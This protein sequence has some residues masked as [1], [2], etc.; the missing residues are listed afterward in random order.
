MVVIASTDLSH[1]HSHVEAQSLDKVLRKDVIN[2]D[3][4]S[5]YE[6]IQAGNSEACGFGG[7]LTGMMLG[8]ET[9]K[10]KSAELLY[11]DSGEV[12]GDRNKVV[13][14]LSAVMY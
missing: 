12:S 3:P 9:G 1:Y 2:M 14:Y 13:G 6:N 4:E 10:G 11:M 5:L 7:V 8:N